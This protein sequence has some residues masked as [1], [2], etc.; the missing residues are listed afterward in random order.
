[1]D[2]PDCWRILRHHVYPR[3]WPY[4]QWSLAARCKWG[5][6]PQRWWRSNTMASGCTNVNTPWLILFLHIVPPWRTK[7]V[8]I[9]VH[10]RNFW[11][12]TTT[13][14]ASWSSFHKMK[15]MSTTLQMWSVTGLS[16][17]EY[18][19]NH[20]SMTSWRRRRSKLKETTTR[21]WRCPSSTWSQ[22]RVASHSTPDQWTRM[23][24]DWRMR[25]SHAS[26]AL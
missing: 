7:T 19:A 15:M 26:S 5:R 13:S 9:Y 14:V 1:M 20:H 16:F 12:Q 10:I 17:I 2:T 6:Q 23:T 18:T 8:Y 21:S 11:R 3:G 4:R 22:Q 25:S 24:V